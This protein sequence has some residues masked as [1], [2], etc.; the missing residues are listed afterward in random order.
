MELSGSTLS[1][2]SVRAYLKSKRDEQAE[3]ERAFEAAKKAELDK[4]HKEFEEREIR[5]EAMEN[6]AWLIRKAIDMG[7]RQALVLRFPAKWLSDN[8]RAVTN[9]DPDWARTLTGF[10]R[11]AG[12]FFKQELEP[13]GFQIKAEIMDWPDG[14]PGDVGIFLLWKRPEEM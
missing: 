4:L 11:R 13:R 7:E 3:K 2:D 10:A 14:M 6:V 5:P 9:Q 8:G 1:A 12:D